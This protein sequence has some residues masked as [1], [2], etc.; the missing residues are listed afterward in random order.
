ME[1]PASKKSSSSKPSPK[2]KSHLK[3]LLNFSLS[4]FGK[5]TKKSFF[6]VISHLLEAYEKEGLI[7]SEEKKMFKNITSF[8][9]KKVSSIMT[10]RADLVMI[11]HDA[12]LEEIKVL[13]TKQGHTRIPVFRENLD[14]I[15]GFIHSKDLARFLCKER[16][17][18]AVTTILRKIL[19]VPGSMKLLD[20]MLRM[21]M[22]RVHIAIVLDEFGGVDGLV[23]IENLV[24]E[25]V[26]DIEDEHD[27]PS[28]SSFFRIK[29]L[30]E[31]TF[32]VGGRVEI[33]KIEEVLQKKIKKRDDDFQTV[34]GLAMALFNRVPEVG[35]EIEKNGM[36]FRIIDADGRLVKL[37]EIVLK[38]KKED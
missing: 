10:S 32:E 18:F 31:K 7:N 5:K 4:L 26:G 16:E 28:E 17:D 34:S 33:R 30:D 38:D 6:S 3:K 20:V 23:T 27:L 21:R 14:E 22:A 13:I 19:F 36:S 37:V 25:I 12:D 35:E 8:G 24:E 1:T 15:I 2:K 29:K 11:K 9:D